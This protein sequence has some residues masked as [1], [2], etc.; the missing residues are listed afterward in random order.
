MNPDA[1]ARFDTIR[2][3]HEGRDRV[4]VS[5]V[6]GQPPP[7]TTKV[8]MNFAGGLRQV[9]SLKLTG[10]DIEEKAALAERTIWSSIPGGR[11]AFEEAHV[12]LIRS[13]H[14]DPETNEEAVAELR[15]VL[16]DHDETK[17]GRAISQK[18][19]EM[20]LASYPGFFGGG[21]DPARPYGVYWPAIV[22]SELVWQEVV[23]GGE[24]TRVEPT[25]PPDSFER[26]HLDVPAVPTP[27]NGSTMRAPLGRIIGAR[28]GDKGGN[29]N[30]GVWTRTD[31]AYAWLEHFLDVERLRAL[32]PECKELDVQRY[33]LPNIRA[34]NFVIVGLLGEG[35]A[36]SVRL[37]PQ[38][39]ALGEYLRAKVVDVPAALL[40]G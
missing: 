21:F 11:E 40:E 33:P 32:M 7:P 9:F 1:T 12:Q 10:L 27:P 2:L 6:R 31:E 34:I 29:A 37:D 39:K 14:E 23:V 22:P 8:C 28:S 26:I 13:D 16:K 19:T 20:A 24:R 3:A 15:F 4:R 17:F 5:G 35:V 18:V 36:S 38:A 25:L 30:L